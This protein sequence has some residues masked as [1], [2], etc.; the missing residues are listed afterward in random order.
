MDAVCY[1]Q[2]LL[3]RPATAAYGYPM[4]IG[5][6]L[7]VTPELLRGYG[8]AVGAGAGPVAPPLLSI[9]AGYP[10]LFAAVESVTPPGARHRTVHAHHEVRLA[11]PIVAGDRLRAAATVESVRSSRP[12]TSVVVRI[13]ITDSD[14][15]SAAVH[16]AVAI[17]R[18]I[19][20]T[21]ESGPPVPAAAVEPDVWADAETCWLGEDQP[22]RYAAATGDTNA[23]HLDP[24]AAQQAGFPGVIAHGLGVFGLALGVLV[25]RVAGGEPGAIRRAAVRFGAPVRPGQDLNVQWTGGERVAFRVLD[26]SGATVLRAGELELV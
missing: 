23:V 25:D 22:T 10:L 4:L 2:T 21:T 19:H 17:V 12:G 20:P 24:V 1:N 5:S 3:S 26:A 18:G 9:V 7:R 14:G 13:D 16:R 6:E 8:D 15:G 11:R